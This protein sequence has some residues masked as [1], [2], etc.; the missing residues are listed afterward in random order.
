[1][2]SKFRLFCSMLI[3]GGMAFKFM[4]WFHGSEADCCKCACGSR[5]KSVIRKR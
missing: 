5:R 1:M 3:L 4:F 2:A